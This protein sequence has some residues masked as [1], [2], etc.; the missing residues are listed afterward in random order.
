MPEGPRFS[1]IHTSVVSCCEIRVDFATRRT[2]MQLSSRVH[3]TMR[4]ASNILVEPVTLASS[5]CLPDKNKKEGYGHTTTLSR[6]RS[7]LH[8][9]PN[10]PCQPVLLPILAPW[11]HYHS[12]FATASHS[13]SLHRAEHSEFQSPTILTIL[14]FNPGTALTSFISISASR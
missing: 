2:P 11:D 4:P 1:I 3:G 10:A 6:V 9:M 5:T 12:Q 13:H 14:T 8:T 7:I